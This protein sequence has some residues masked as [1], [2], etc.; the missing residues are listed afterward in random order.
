MATRNLFDRG[1]LALNLHDEAPAN[2]VELLH[3]TTWGTEGGA[4]YLHFNTRERITKQLDPQFLTLHK[5]E[6][7]LG[8]LGFSR[9]ELRQPSGVT[10]AFYIRYLSMM[11]S[12]QR[13]NPSAASSRKRSDG[14]VKKMVGR[15]MSK[16]QEMNVIP[17]TGPESAM[18]Y[19]FVELENERSIEMTQAMGFEQV[20]KFST[21]I[22]SRF[23]PKRDANVEYL[24]PEDLAEVKERTSEFYKD[25]ALYSDHNIFREGI[26]LVYRDGGEIVA[27]IKAHSCHWQMVGM[28]GLSGKLIMGLLPK[29]PFM[30]RLFN[31]NAFKFAA[32]EGLW[33]KPGYETRLF[34]LM[35]SALV[36]LKLNTAMIWV[37]RKCPLDPVLRSGHLGILQHLNSDVPANVVARFIKVPE[38][39]K[40]DIRNKPLFISAFDST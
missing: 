21:I 33:F 39:I 22:F 32:F 37:D 16:P 23:N 38:S 31:P 20:G 8:I 5:G 3:N 29:I 11:S 36:E 10:E 4:R 9:R 17:G 30:N 27:G 40:E 6:R 35:E 14:L 28:P 2:S 24:Q 12:F 26:N 34:E 15:L 7:L 19:A 25:H 18:F 1:G 13:Q